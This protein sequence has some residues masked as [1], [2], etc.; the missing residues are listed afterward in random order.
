[1][2]AHKRLLEMA[3]TPVNRPVFAVH[4]G[5]VSPVQDGKKDDSNRGG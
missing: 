4:L 2:F 1:M 3:T 5:H